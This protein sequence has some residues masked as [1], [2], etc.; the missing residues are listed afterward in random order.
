MGV[1]NRYLSEVACRC[2]LYE[3]KI[4]RLSLG[5]MQVR[6]ITQPTVW[7]EFSTSRDRK[8]QLM[9]MIATTLEGEPSRWGK[10]YTQ[11]SCEEQSRKTTERLHRLSGKS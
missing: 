9:L 2:H 6:L 7:E 3:R 11:G 5:E 4:T 10:A 1:S 8:P